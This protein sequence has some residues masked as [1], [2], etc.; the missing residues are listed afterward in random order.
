[1]ELIKSFK[2][3]N[4]F[5]LLASFFAILA[6]FMYLPKQIFIDFGT[7]SITYGVK[8]LTFITKSIFVGY[9]LVLISGIAI[10]INALFEF[11]NK[12]IRLTFSLAIILML[13]LGIILMLNVTNFVKNNVKYD[14]FS[15]AHQAWVVQNIISGEVSTSAGPRL[16]TVGSVIAL[17]L[18]GTSNAIQILSNAKEQLKKM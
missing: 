7:T 16:G 2:V 5:K 14:S 8:D 12:I 3:S 4:F 9:I 10:A 17:S 1:M 15:T 13:V 18:F 6:F 11:K